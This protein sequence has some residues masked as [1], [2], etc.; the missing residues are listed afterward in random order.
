MA[1]AD[2]SDDQNPEGL[3]LPKDA[4]GTYEFVKVVT[5]YLQAFPKSFGRG[6]SDR[7]AWWS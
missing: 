7:H 3:A 2:A 4:A 5:Q 6:Q 1:V